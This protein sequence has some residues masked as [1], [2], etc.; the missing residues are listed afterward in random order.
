MSVDGGQAKLQFAR[1][2]S[3]CRAAAVCTAVAPGLSSDG[4]G[5]GPPTHELVRKAQPQPT[6][7][8]QVNDLYGIAERRA[9]HKSGFT[10]EQDG[11]ASGQGVRIVNG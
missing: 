2:A 10:L 9:C 3:C 8:P 5:T 6:P 4:A 11:F 7:N 1:D